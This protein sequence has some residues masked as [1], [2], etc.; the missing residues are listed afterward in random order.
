[1]VWL[2][3]FAIAGALLLAMTWLAASV[4][5]GT[6]LLA[7][8][9]SLQHTAAL[10]TGMQLFGAALAW[11]IAR[12]LSA[13][14]GFRRTRRGLSEAGESLSKARGLKATSSPAGLL[15]GGF[16]AG[17]ITDRVGA[18]HEEIVTI[19]EIVRTVEPWFEPD[20]PLHNA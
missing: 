18:N 15:A 10:I 4:W 12:L 2:V 5:L 13:R 19:L 9:W 20:E 14:I 11:L 6:Y 17:F 8:G 16:T 3:V 1:M 7:E